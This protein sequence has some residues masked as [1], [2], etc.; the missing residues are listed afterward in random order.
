MN[1]KSKTSKT[2]IST[3]QLA[4]L[5]ILL[6]LVIV[7]QS[8]SSVGVVTL[9]LCLVPITLGAIVLDW[10]C[11]GIL[12]FVFGLV[13][14]FW[15]ILGK[16]LF[17]L[18]LF[19]ANPIMT[20]LICIVKGTLCGI[21]PAFIYQVLKKHNSLAAV[22]A[23]S[24]AAPIVNTGIFALGCIIIQSDVMTATD[25]LLNENFNMG[26]DL[27]AMGFISVLFGVLITANFFFELAV[28]LVLAP[29]L[30]RVTEV[31]TKRIQNGSS[32]KKA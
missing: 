32:R 5:G 30:N 3:L 10:K 28:N 11:S 31:V 7:L 23:A 14:I 16:D 4:E 27:E 22:F 2:G 21:V 15:G 24:I 13:T 17:T 18:Y 25:K 20:I 8:F 9:C 29:A 1:I 19:Q 26:M 12:G 6:A